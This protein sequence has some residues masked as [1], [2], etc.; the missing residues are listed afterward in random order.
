MTTTMPTRQQIER[1]EPLD[2]NQTRSEKPVS[3]TIEAGPAGL[4]VRV[5]YQGTLASIPAAIEKLRAAG[6]LE[7]VQASRPVVTQGLH[8]PMGEKKPRA[9]TVEPI[10]QPDGTPC[11]PTHK[12]PLSEGQYGLYC[13][14]KAKPGENANPKGYCNLKFTD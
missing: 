7:L 11:C 8:S 9:E 5:D 2:M 12:R 10:Y 13:S 6:I 1:A 4:V 3:I 14:A